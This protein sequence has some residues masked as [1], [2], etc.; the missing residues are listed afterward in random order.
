MKEFGNYGVEETKGMYTFED[1]K[2]SDK[3]ASDGCLGVVD[4]VNE[5]E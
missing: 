3:R 5:E 1:G 4:C 2:G